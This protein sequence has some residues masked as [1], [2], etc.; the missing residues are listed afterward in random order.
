MY[1]FWLIQKPSAV[2]IQGVEVFNMGL[3]LKTVLSF[4]FTPYFGKLSS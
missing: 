1:L 3:V 4:I 2:C